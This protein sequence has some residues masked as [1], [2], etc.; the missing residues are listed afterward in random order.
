MFTFFIT[1]CNNRYSLVGKGH[2]TVEDFPIPTKLNNL[3]PFV[4]F[5]YGFKINKK[6][7]MIEEKYS[8]FEMG[9]YES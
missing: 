7:L 3:I 6:G 9:F 5:I 8:D 4:T 1:I 2:S